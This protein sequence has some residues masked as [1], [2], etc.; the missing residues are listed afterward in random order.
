MAQGTPLIFKDCGGTPIKVGDT[1]MY[2]GKTYTISPYGLALRTENNEAYPLSRME[3]SKLTIL[4]EAAAKETKEETKEESKEEELPVTP[5]DDMSSLSLYSDDEIARELRR[6]GYY[7]NIY[8]VI[9]LGE[10]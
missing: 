6:R 5:S 4:T 9:I 1:I 8:K 3:S 7:G 2:E 10:A